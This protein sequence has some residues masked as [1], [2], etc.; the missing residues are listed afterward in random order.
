MRSTPAISVA[1][2]PGTIPGTGISSKFTKLEDAD[3]KPGHFT[4][5][6]SARLLMEVIKG[7][8]PADGGRFL[9]YAGKDILF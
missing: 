2:H 4:P 6:E 8:K 7:L 1:L 3:I 9:D 5:E